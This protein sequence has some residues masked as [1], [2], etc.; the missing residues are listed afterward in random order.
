[1]NLW[2]VPFHGEDLFCGEGLDLVR[3]TQFNVFIKGKFSPS[4]FSFGASCD[5][6]AMGVAG[7]FVGLKVFPVGGGKR[8]TDFII[9]NVFPVPLPGLDDVVDQ[10]DHI[11]GFI[12][13]IE[14]KNTFR[15]R[16]HAVQLGD[17]GFG[18]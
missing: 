2:T 1:M 4:D 5:Y 7:D 9:S 16:E 12:S 3:V 18:I 15:H 14:Y 17:E 11:E 13:M 8:G 10:G 6:D